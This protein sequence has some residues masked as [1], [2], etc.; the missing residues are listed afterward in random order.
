MELVLFF[1]SSEYDRAV[2]AATIDQRFRGVQVLGCTTAGEIGPCGC[3]D[4]SLTGVS[5]GSGSFTAVTGH[6]ERMRELEIADGEAFTK[7]LLQELDGVAPSGGDLNT[8]AFLLVDG[9][10]MREGLL[11]RALQEGLREIP[12]IG[13]SAGDG[14]AFGMP[15]SARTATS[16]RTAPAWIWCRTS[17]VRSTK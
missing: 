13:G 9:L 8:F 2:L 15:S 5:F 11:A 10:S 12:L 1:C 16:C 3:R 6:L 17:S 4:H 14:L 7:A